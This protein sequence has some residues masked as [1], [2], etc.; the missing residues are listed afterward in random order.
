ME[1][2]DNF[3]PILNECHQKTTKLAR[4]DFGSIDI[5]PKKTNI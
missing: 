3:P 1:H 5:F 4:R 2:A